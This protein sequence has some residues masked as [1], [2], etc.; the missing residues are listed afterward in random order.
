MR[1]R[2]L[3]FCVPLVVLLVLAAG[4]PS[5][6]ADAYTVTSS[7]DA[8]A[9]TLRDAIAT[10]NGVAGPHTIDF[11]PGLAGSTILLSTVG[12]TTWGPTAL[13]IAEDIEI[14]GDAALGI[15]IARDTGGTEMRLFYV[16]EDAA[17]TLINVTLRDGL[18]RG[19]DG[20]AGAQRGGG[21]GGSA[22]AGGAIFNEG[23]LDI[24]YSLLLQR[25]NS[26][27]CHKRWP[28]ARLYVPAESSGCHS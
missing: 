20:G 4:T 23:T 17:L 24:R 8:G 15:T 22:A 19:N 28:V 11:A 1:I 18:I 25:Q 2:K 26:V 6:N 13:A 10:A 14:T 5:A 7:A 3:L 21:G 16:E 9:G 12:D 27:G